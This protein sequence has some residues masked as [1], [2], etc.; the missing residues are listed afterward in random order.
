M[1]SAQIL[2]TRFTRTV[3]LAALVAIAVTLPVVTFQAK[4]KA[5]AQAFGESQTIEGRVNSLTT[6]PLGEVDGAVLDDGSVIHWPPHLADR[7]TAVAV[8]GDRIRAAGRMETGPAGD[9]HFEIAKVTNLR[10]SA[11]AE[12]ELGPPP[13]GPARPV[14]PPRPGP[15]ARRELL[16]PRAG[17]TKTATGRVKTLTTAPMGELD[18]AVLDDATVIH[19]PPHLAD[20]FTP[21]VTRGDRIKVSGWMETGPAGDTHLE[22]QTV[23][24]LNSNASASA[25]GGPRSGRLQSDDSGDFAPSRAATADVECRL[26]VLEDQIAQLREEIR[27]LRDEL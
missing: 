20:R 15:L 6:A 16:D 1:N 7:F 13:A 21:V 8:T 11:S 4:A 10:T 27:N 24:N 25:D 14:G 3:H 9:T 19:W 18:G 12:N 26:K 2:N 17:Q 5:Q 22:V 23:V